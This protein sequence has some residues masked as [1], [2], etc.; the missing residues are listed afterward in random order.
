MSQTSIRIRDARPEDAEEL[1]ALTCA[2]ESQFPLL[3]E[4]GERSPDPE[5]LRQRIESFSARANCRYLLAELEGEMVGW[6]WAEGGVP[7]RKAKSVYLVV[8]MKS[9]AQ[10]RGIGSRLFGELT[11]W[12]S[13]QHLSRVELIVLTDNAPA[14]A[15]YRKFGFE[16][17]GELRNFIELDGAPCNAYMMAAIPPFL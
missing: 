1:M 17:E 5:P 11:A 6:L 10:G 4:P 3:Y 8:A 7:R 12:A 2:L 15:L 13:A 9:E 16:I 14:I